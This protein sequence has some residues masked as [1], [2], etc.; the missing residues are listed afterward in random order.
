[1]RSTKLPHPRLSLLRDLLR[2]RTHQLARWFA[3]LAA[4]TVSGTLGARIHQ[5][6][7]DFETFKLAHSITFL[8]QR[9]SAMPTEALL[10]A[11]SRGSTNDTEEPHFL[12]RFPH[13]F[14]CVNSQ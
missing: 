7:Q 4:C 12:R 13:R 8:Q 5:C 11:G 14:S 6:I 3:L 10:N 1:M 2:P 9:A